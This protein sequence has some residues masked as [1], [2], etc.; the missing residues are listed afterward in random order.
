MPDA[1]GQECRA[2]AMAIAACSTVA[3]RLSVPGGD[4]TTIT[5]PASRDL[6]A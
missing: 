1:G 4:A 3:Y 6:G 5:N 2:S